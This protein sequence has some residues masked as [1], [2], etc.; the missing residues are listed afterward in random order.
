MTHFG[1]NVASNDWNNNVISVSLF[2]ALQ[3]SFLNLVL[4]PVAS[5]QGLIREP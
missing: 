1:K 3:L 5:A 4:L 2:C